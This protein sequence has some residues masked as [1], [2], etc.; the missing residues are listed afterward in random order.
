MRPSTDLTPFWNSDTTYYTSKSEHVHDWTK[1]NAQY[2]E[3]V[4]L[5]GKTKDEIR[6]AILQTVDTLY[7]PNKPRPSPTPAL[8]RLA[9]TPVSPK[10]EEY[11][12]WSVRITSKRYELKTSYTVYLFYGT[13]PESPDDWLTAHNQ[14]G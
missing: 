5:E 4:G 14:L 11:L 9:F 3:F 1:F 12:D 7:N 10:D 6:T 8:S 2:P 13:P